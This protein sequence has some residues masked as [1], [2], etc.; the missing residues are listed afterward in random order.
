MKNNIQALINVGLLTIVLNSLPTN[1]AIINGIVTGT[2]QYSSDSNDFDET[3]FFNAG[4]TNPYVGSNYTINFSI[5]TALAPLDGNIY[6][7][8]PYIGHY[9]TDSGDS[10][11]PQPHTDWLQMSL[12]VEEQTIDLNG[13]RSSYISLSDGTQNQNVDMLDIGNSD[14]FYVDYLNYE[15]SELVLSM[16][17][18]DTLNNLITGDSLNQSFSW[19]NNGSPSVYAY[20]HLAIGR[21][22]GTSELGYTSY[23]SA[24][25]D[26]S[27]DTIQY[28]VVPVPPAIILF[29]SGLIGLI[30]FRR[31]I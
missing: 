24:S 21:G 18:N 4:N 9:A 22:Q 28:S 7:V 11:N 30:G 10:Y 29:V 13:S 16:W 17:D 25:L 15:Q 3:F 26:L 8:D 5:D 2:V 6:G 20:G 12:T 1:A 14:A 27:I 19:V 23:D 31:L